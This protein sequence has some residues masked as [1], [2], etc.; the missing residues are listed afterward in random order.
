MAHRHAPDHHHHK[1]CADAHGTASPAPGTK[2]DPVCGMTVNV[3]DAKHTSEYQGETYYFCSGHCKARFEADPQRFLDAEIKARAAAEEAK[4]KPKGTLYTCPM[5]PEIVQEGPGT[6]PKCGMALEPMGVPA[7]DEGPNPEL[8]DFRRRFVVGAIFAVPLVLIA[9][10]P[11]VGVPLHRWVPA[12]VTQWIELV[13]A[14]PVVLW[15]GLPFLERGI[16]SIRNRSPNMWTLIAIGVTTAFV[17]SVAAVFAP[18]IFPEAVREH[19][20]TVGVYFEAA[21]VIVVLVLLGQLLELRA[22]ER[23]GAAIRALMDLAPKTALRIAEDG[24]EAEVPVDTLMPGDRVRIRPGEAVPVD[25]SVLDG[26]SGVDEQLVTG[27]PL[28]VDKKPGD[29]LTGGTLNRT[30]SLIM[31]VERVAS[32]T[33]L[34]RIVEMVASAQRTR[35]PIQSLADKVAAYFV[36]AVI[37]VAILAFPAWLLFGPPP[38]LAHAVIA[39]VSVLI[40]ACPC[41]LGLAT[42]ISIMMATGRGARSGILIRNAE[43]LERLASVDT[44]VIDKT[45]TLTVGRP[46]LTDIKPLAGT[47]EQTLFRLAASLERGSEHP[48]AQ[49][50]VAAARSRSI[51]IVEPDVFDTAPGKGAKGIVDGQDVALGNVALMQDLS[52]AVSD[53]D[54][55]TAELRRDGKTALYAAAGGRLIGILAFADEIKP[56]T[57]AAL[58]ALADKGLR[59][60]MATGDA[61]ATADAVARQLGITEVHAG[62]LPEKKADLVQRLKAEGRRVAFAGDGVNDAPALAAAD[63]GIAMGTGADV[64]KESAGITLPEGDLMGIARARKLAETTLANI[65]QNLVF[66]FGY[67]ALGV[68]IA[69]GVLYPVLGWLLSPMIAAAAMSL[70]SVSV[71]GNSLRLG[72]ADID[73]APR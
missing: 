26:H 17:Y 53:Y 42:P 10:A 61:G 54:D 58:A 2:I 32:D 64:A 37:A 59:V 38:A 69:A 68:P 5:H 23:T 66:A 73:I 19:D 49:A 45:G 57:P 65:R 39:A 27:E 15:C 71:I 46:V 56:T 33:M 24:A 43:A 30:G 40:I 29:K 11:H 51:S 60:I 13:L 50:I 20:G 3:A 18:G 31:K 14:T 1:S 62:V 63:V 16:A 67:N 47:T 72:R 6:C 48:L 28:P 34:A 55:A 9:M 36:P 41:A 44:L 35:A 12:H 52:I 21:A 70:S 25:G 4:S 22:R 8:V 7:A